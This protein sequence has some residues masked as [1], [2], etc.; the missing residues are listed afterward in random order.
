[1]LS[2]VENDSF[3]DADVREVDKDRYKV[4]YWVSAVYL[5]WP[6]CTLHGSSS[7]TAAVELVTELT[8]INTH[9]LQHMPL[10]QAG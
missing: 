8:H 4:M 9:E 10:F 7:K 2:P 6:L 3:F 5:N 1:V